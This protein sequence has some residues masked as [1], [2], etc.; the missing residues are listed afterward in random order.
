MSIGPSIAIASPPTL[1]DGKIDG[2]KHRVTGSS[3]MARWLPPGFQ[4]RHRHRRRRQRRRHALRHSR[5][6]AWN[7]CA[8]S[9]PPCRRGSGAAS[10]PTTTCS[11][12]KASWTSWRTR[13]ARIPSHFAATCSKKSPRLTAAI[14]LAASKA[15]WGSALPARAGRGICAAG[16]VRKLHRDRRRSGGGQRRRSPCAAAS[17]RAVDTGIVVN[18]DTIVAQLQGGLIFGVTAA[19]YGEITI[20]NGRVQQSNFNDYRM[21]RIDETPAIEVHLIKSG[22]AAG[23]IGETGTTAAPP[24]IGNAIFAATGIRAAAIADR[25]RRS[26]RE[27]T[28]MS[29]L[30]SSRR[31]LALPL[32]GRRRH[33]RSGARRISLDRSWRPARWISRAD[34]RVALAEYRGGDPT[35][36]PART[37]SASLVQRGEYLARA[38]DCAACHTRRGRPAFSGG[39]AFV[40]PFGTLYSTNITPDK[41]TGIGDYSDAEFLECPPQG[42]PPRRQASL[43]GDALRQLYHDDGRRRAGDQGLSLQPCARARGRAAPTRWSFRSTSAGS[44]A[45]GRC[46]SIATSA[47]SRIASAARNGTAAPISSRAMAH[48]GECHTPRNLFQALDNSGE[49]R[50]RRPGR[51]ARLQHHE[52]SEQRHRRLERRGSRELSGGRPCRQAWHGGRCEWARRSIRASVT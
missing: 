45:S 28:G 20:E 14:E 36:V 23:G 11:P 18:P 9:R 13:R 44:W 19:L 51:L 33:R 24:A 35:G 29:A 30:S 43:S 12:S 39:L 32:V 6:C 38:A 4:E 47:S 26:R 25:S 52:R 21:L 22:E 27:E 1:K 8:T 10:A 34:D 16:V 7:S 50:R 46:C 2:W 31:R 3:V 49:V 17:S 40:L 42:D 41:E 15:G 37:R 48:C 5:I